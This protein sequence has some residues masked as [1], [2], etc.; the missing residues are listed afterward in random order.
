[1]RTS[2]SRPSGS[3]SKAARA[4]LLVLSVSRNIVRIA[5][6]ATNIA[7]DVIFR[8]DARDVRHRIEHNGDAPA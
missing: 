4:G 3:A 8:V 1:V 5:D 7:E 6:L 2:F